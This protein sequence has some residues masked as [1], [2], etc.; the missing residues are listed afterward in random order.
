MY[1]VLVDFFVYFSV[2]DNLSRIKQENIRYCFSW[3]YHKFFFACISLLYL[4]LALCYMKKY[5]VF[6][7]IYYEK[8]HPI[9]YLV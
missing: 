5:H 7:E 6:N 2:C 1:L 3:V 8:Y 9:M 4:C